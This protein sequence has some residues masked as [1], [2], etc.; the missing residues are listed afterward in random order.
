M[1][2]FPSSSN[3]N[4]LGAANQRIPWQLRLRPALSATVGSIVAIIVIVGGLLTVRRLL[5]QMQGELLPGAMLALALA[6]AVIVTYARLAWRRNFPIESSTDLSN[7]DLIIGWGS[8]LGLVCL[9][10]GCC[11]PGYRTI[12]WLIWLPILVAD[13]IWRQDFFD[14]GQPGTL[15][16]TDDEVM[17]SPT[18]TVPS[19]ES[20]NESIVQQLFRMRDEGGKETVYGTVGADFVAGQRVSV[21]HV[22]FCPPLDYLPDIEAETLPGSFARIKVA[23]ALAHGVRLDVRLPQVAEEDCR[24]WIDMAA[25]PRPD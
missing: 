4:S 18:G 20:L 22:G 12:D 13:Q 9:A 1:P 8:S 3:S 11:Y 24:I 25:Q 21:V 23:Q 14:T 17:Y 15:G 6:S 7:V 5:G 16:A 2:L 10:V 19:E